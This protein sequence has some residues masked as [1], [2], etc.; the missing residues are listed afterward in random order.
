MANRKEHNEDCMAI[1]GETFDYVHK[2]LDELA[3]PAESNML[4]INHRRFRHHDEGVKKVREM[5]GDEA[6]KAAVVHIERDEGY[7]KLKRII[8]NQ[9]PEEPK[10]INIKEL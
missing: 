2:W 5:W 3:F 10:F 9:Y 8:E 4:N 6:A 7:V 1:F